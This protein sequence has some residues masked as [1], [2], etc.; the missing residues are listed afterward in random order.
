MR[1]VAVSGDVV[2]FYETIRQWC[3]KLGQTYANALR[4]RRDRPGDKWHL[5]EVFIQG[6]DYVPRVVV[7]DELASYGAP[8]RIV[9]PSVEHRKSKYLNNRRRTHPGPPGH[10]NER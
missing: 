10:A 2:V 8:H 1:A 3:A 4:R 6:L 5:D 7:T 9:M